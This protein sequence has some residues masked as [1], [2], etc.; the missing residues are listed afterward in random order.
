MSYAI[1][2]IEDGALDRVLTTG[3][4]DAQLRPDVEVHDHVLA[5]RGEGSRDQSGWEVAVGGSTEI[6]DCGAAQAGNQC[7]G[8]TRIQV[9]EA[10]SGFTDGG[11]GGVDHAGC[12][13]AG[14]GY[15]ERE[16]A[17]QRAAVSVQSEGAAPVLIQSEELLDAD[18]IGD[19]DEFSV[20]PGV[21]RS[22]SAV[23]GGVGKI[24]QTKKGL[25]CPHCG[26][27]GINGM[28][29]LMLHVDRM[30]SKHFT[31]NICKVEF[32]D[33]YLFNLHSPMCFYMCPL[34]G[35]NFQD[36]RESRLKGHLRRHSFV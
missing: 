22:S 28:S 4:A 3:D 21:L 1:G 26:V 25:T 23:N 12:E 16:E 15:E 20:P 8:D 27:I 2:L 6:M 5:D 19:L 11:R 24:N 30:H 36:K 7:H 10:G 17:G 31:C 33:R 18:E 34:E 13:V 29:K 35:C 32:V 9:V 14:R